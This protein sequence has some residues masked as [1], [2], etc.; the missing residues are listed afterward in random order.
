MYGVIEKS[1]GDL[2]KYGDVDFS[3]ESVFDSEL[4]EIRSDV[5]QPGKVKGNLFCDKFHRLVDGEWIEIDNL[6]GDDG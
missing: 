2:I 1:T 6:V 5:P 4:H 3:Q